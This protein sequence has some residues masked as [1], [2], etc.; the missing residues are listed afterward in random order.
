MSDPATAT[1]A[2]ASRSRCPDA[3]VVAFELD[4]Y[5]ARVAAEVAA[6]NGVAT[7]IE[8][9]GACTPAEL[10]A[11]EPAA[12]SVV[13]CDAEG[14]E[15]D[16][17]D[18]AAV[19]WLASAELLVEVHETFRPNVRAELMGRLRD[20]HELEWIAPG[21]RHLEDLPMFWDLPLVSET[22][23][24]SLYS[25]LRLWRTSWLHAVPA[26]PAAERAPQFL[27]P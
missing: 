25:E 10:A 20:T 6:A 2:S 8:Q 16:L 19:P 12:R 22:Q 21:A 18:P 5:P 26:R 7:R 1:T 13:F 4:P 11:L 14:A 27:F 17:I 24:E 15:E 3:R 9:R 23:T